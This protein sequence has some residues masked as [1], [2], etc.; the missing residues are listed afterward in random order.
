MF[1]ATIYQEGRTLTRQEVGEL[2]FDTIELIRREGL[3]ETLLARGITGFTAE[4]QGSSFVFTV[5]AESGPNDDRR[6]QA[7]GSL[8]V[9]ARNP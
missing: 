3:I 2:V 5:S 9:M 4:R 7:S 1:Y 6:R 8:R